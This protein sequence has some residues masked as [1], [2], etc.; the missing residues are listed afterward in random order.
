MDTHFANRT[1]LATRLREKGVSLGYASD[2]ANGRR[3]PS[4]P[5]AARIEEELGIPATAW[6]ENQRLC[7]AERAQKALQGS[8]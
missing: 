2:L 6:I 5:L 8:D 4:L 7:E 1:A 3:L